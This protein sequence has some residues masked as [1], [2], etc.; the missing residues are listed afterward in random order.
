MRND[1]RFI[2]LD[3]LSPDAPKK[4]AHWLHHYLG[5]FA[6]RSGREYSHSVLTER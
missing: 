4:V 2:A 5:R 6:P 1:E 3:E